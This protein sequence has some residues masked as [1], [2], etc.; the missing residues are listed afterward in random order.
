MPVSAWFGRPSGV[1]V[2]AETWQLKVKVDVCIHRAR[3]L[4]LF[5]AFMLSSPSR[6]FISSFV[7]EAENAVSGFLPACR[8]KALNPH[9]AQ[10]STVLCFMLLQ[11]LE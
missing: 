8:L 2:R 1:R 9:I 7:F 10:G 3:V 11:E 6:S 5:K 4:T